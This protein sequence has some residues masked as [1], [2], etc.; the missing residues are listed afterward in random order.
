MRINIDYVILTIV[1]IIGCV[2]IGMM[3]GDIG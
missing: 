3:G 2:L 1:F